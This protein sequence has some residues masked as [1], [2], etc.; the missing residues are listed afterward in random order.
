MFNHQAEKTSAQFILIGA[1]LAT[2]FILMS[3]VTDPVNATK[4]FI[5]GGLGVA[6]IAVLIFFNLKAVLREFK[7]YLIL[8]TIFLITALNAVINSESPL[9]Q[10]IYGSFGRNTGFLA[11]L[12]LTLISLGAL[13]LRESVQ[14]E[15]IIWGLQFAGLVNVLYCAWVLAFGDFLRWNNPY[16]NILGLFG[17]PDFIS[18]FLGIFIST[19]FAFF[20][21]PNRSFRYRI[22]SVILGFLAFYEI[23]RSHAI[24][25]IV[26]TA[27]G[28]AIVGFFAIRSYVKKQILTLTYVLSVMGI[29]LL[30]VLG[31]FQK[32]PLSFIYKTSVSLRGAYWDAGLKMGL[33]HP[34]TGVGMDA[35]GDWYRRA[36]S[37][38]AATVLPGP[39]TFTNAA[40]NVVIDFFAY[41]GF[42]LLISYLGMLALAAISIVKVI[43]RSNT[44]DATFVAMVAA[45]A[46]YEVQSIISIN[47][48]GLA[49]WGW[50]LTGALVAYE[51]A[52][53]NQ[54]NQ[55]EPIKGKVGKLK[56]KSS[57]SV[58]SP[59][60]AAGIGAVVGLVIAAPPLSA[61]MKWRA[62]LTSQDASKAL[63]ALAPNYLNPSDSQR[64]AQAVQLFASNNL[65]DQARQ[66][67][68]QG[69]S[70]NPNY[71]DAWKMLYFLPNATPDEKSRALAN[72]KRLD[73]LNPD[74]TTP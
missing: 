44:F 3:T 23:H 1:P 55:A 52:T 42:P 54:G 68:L 39:K 30:G 17:N 33:D 53:R 22:F 74:V 63:A 4:F 32:G 69:I 73:P 28:I 62:A 71:F 15:K 25:G 11:Y 46:C 35:Y 8:S 5:S 34:W 66:V 60:L 29:G 70:Y 37:L 56:F 49:I 26:V 65:P 50:L 10:N 12:M 45:W 64:F 36:R 59:N 41:G 40:H 21:S 19:L 24:Q 67:A 47:Q 31:A 72:M 38:N 20:I 61:D 51:S 7:L 6:L 16:G 43:K 48:V 9:S 2:L 58:F 18:A 27:G 14:F 57:G 13:N